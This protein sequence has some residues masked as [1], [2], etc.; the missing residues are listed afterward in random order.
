[1]IKPKITI[2]LILIIMGSIVCSCS[3]NAEVADTVETETVEAAYS[4]IPVEESF[5]NTIPETSETTAEATPT[6]G[7]TQTSPQESLAEEMYYALIDYVRTYHAS[8]YDSNIRYTFSS[9]ISDGRSYPCLCIGMDGT[10]T[11]DRYIVEDE[12][13]VLLDQVTFDGA[14]LTYHEI[15]QIPYAYED[16][17]WAEV[18]SIDSV[19]LENYVPGGTYYGYIYAISLD[20][21]KALAIIGDLMDIV[22]GD[23]GSIRVSNQRLVLVN[24]DRNCHIE[25]TFIWLYGSDEDDTSETDISILPYSDGP[26][27]FS[28]TVFFHH[29]L[30]NSYYLSYNGWFE[31]IAIME[32]VVIENSTITSMRLGWR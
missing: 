18:N 16:I 12:E 19:R 5:E 2:A 24:I 22:N 14:H 29:A 30:D 4:V 20:G 11:Y 25:D 21:R 15:I 13:V 8:N 32:P 3:T 1:M 17:F 28:N 6:P 26:N 31:A 10:N 9:Y 27:N 23:P 7:Q